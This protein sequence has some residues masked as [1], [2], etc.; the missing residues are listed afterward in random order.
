V[1]HPNICEWGYSGSD[2]SRLIRTPQ[3]EASFLAADAGQYRLTG[4]GPFFLGGPFW[5]P[6]LST[7]AR[8][9]SAAITA[10]TPL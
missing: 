9:A 6:F 4:T 8:V 3:L 5:E 10:D 1:A 7:R 2:Q